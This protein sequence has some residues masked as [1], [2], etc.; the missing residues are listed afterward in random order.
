VIPE[1][2]DLQR[3]ILALGAAVLGGLA[4]ARIYAPSVGKTREAARPF[5]LTLVMLS[6][7]TAGAAL[8]IGDSMARAF[9]LVGA[10]SIV[11]FRTVVDD[12]RDTAFVVFAVV[13]GMACGA[14]AVWTAFAVFAC[15]GGVALLLS[16]RDAGAVAAGI[17]ARLLVRTAAGRDAEPLIAP[18]LHARGAG[19]KIAGASVARQGAALETRFTLRLK[20]ASDAAPLVRELNATD[21]V[22]HV[23]L[24]VD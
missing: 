23:E 17:T 10:L 13:V 6:V 9:G 2:A 21:G 4:V 19:S 11:R 20:D 15:G 14:G 16:R 5:G 1:L 18:V 7:L 24:E 3:E 8:M 12:T 22:Q